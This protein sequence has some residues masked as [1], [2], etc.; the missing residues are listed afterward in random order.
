MNNKQDFD[1]FAYYPGFV[2][3]VYNIEDMHKSVERITLIEFKKGDTLMG[4][5]RTHGNM[6]SK[7]EEMI[8]QCLP[9]PEQCLFGSKEN[10]SEGIWKRYL[11]KL[12]MEDDKKDVRYLRHY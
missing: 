11:W 1:V 3:N 12:I 6:R 8:H 9:A 5:F 4:Q 10:I 7:V 2:C